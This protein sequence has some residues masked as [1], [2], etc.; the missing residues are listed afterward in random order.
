MPLASLVGVRG[1][2]SAELVQSLGVDSSKIMAQLD[3]AWFLDPKP[4]AAVVREAARHSRPWVAV[5]LTPLAGD[6]GTYLPVLQSL[7]RQFSELAR[8]I[9]A[10]LVFVPHWNALPGC[11]SDALTARRLFGFLDE[12]SRARLLPVYS[13]E[14][15]CWLT[16]QAGLV[17]STRYH[18]IVFGLSAG[19][20][21]VG[22]YPDE[23]TRV[24]LS[25]C[26]RHAG[27]EQHAISWDAAL[28]GRLAS[29]ALSAVDQRD[30]IRRQLASRA[31]AWRAC[32]ARKWSRVARALKW[33]DPPLAASPPAAAVTVEEE[34]AAPA[35]LPAPRHRPTSVLDV[36]AVVLTRN[37]S[38]RLERCLQSIAAAGIAREL[39]VVVD[40]TTTDDSE[41]I[42]RRFTPKVLRMETHGYIECCLAQMAAACSGDFVLRI[43]DDETLGGEWDALAGDA[44]DSGAF[45]HF[46]VPRRW[47]VPG[48]DCF[49]S[50]DEWFPDLQLRLFRNDPALIHWPPGLHEHL[51]VE[52]A[53]AVLW[54]RW[55]DH[56]V[57][58]QQ[59]RA[60][61]ARKCAAYRHIRPEKHLSHFYLWEDQAVRLSPCDSNGATA[62]EPL[63]SGAE[64]LFGVD[65]TAAPYKVDGWSHAEP[66]GTWTDGH[67]A[68][69][70][71]PL[72]RSP[73]G[74]VEV[75]LEANAFIRPA[76]PRLNVSVRCAQTVVA[77]WRLEKADVASYR[78]IVPA[79]LAARGGAL[80]LSF[81]IES[82]KSP[83][84]LGESS[85]GRRLGFGVHRLRLTW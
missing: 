68:V 46:L 13:G 15:V 30:A 28:E 53:G 59:S 36:S 54:D 63:D 27:L 38:G 60:E 79:S 56:H 26:L 45:T 58:W 51:V 14:D 73:G 31:A 50:S 25:E 67:Q 64:V 18:P 4:S 6:P 33:P 12:P 85:D 62:A 43:D 22:I 10:D 41:S 39:V 16:R 66:W 75:T 78:A 32:E 77:E 37:G 29:A 83:R 23:H 19:V 71:L 35:P 21:C 20:P 44:N 74:P 24:R 61:R 57:L 9:D 81:H 34:P 11:E 49:I 42:A 72:K 7:G 48:E 80:V 5:T 17:V 8:V 47:L 3:D 52:G 82:P 76:Q 2:H 1:H 55:I 40:D 65:G 69:L 70:R 84:E